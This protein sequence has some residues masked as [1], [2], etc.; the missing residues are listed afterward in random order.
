[1]TAKLR[2]YDTYDAKNTEK[3]P[4]FNVSLNNSVSRPSFKKSFK[5]YQTDF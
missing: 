1:M 2:L 5:K 4:P 3:G